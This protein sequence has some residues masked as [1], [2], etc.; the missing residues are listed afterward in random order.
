LNRFAEVML[1]GRKP[2]E[3]TVVV[4]PKLQKQRLAFEMRKWE[5]ELELERQRMEMERL[6]KEKQ[7]KQEKQR[8]ET[9]KE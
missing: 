9:E 6:E 7:L 2:K 5:Q 3:P 4:D 8:I 1:A